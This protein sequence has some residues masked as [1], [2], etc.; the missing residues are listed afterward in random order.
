MK[1][2]AEDTPDKVAYNIM[3]EGATEWQS[4]TWSEYYQIC[5][6]SAKSLMALGLEAHEAIAVRG[7]NSPEWFA[8]DV[9]AIL[10][11]G[12]AAGIYTTNGPEASAYIVSHSGAKIV[13]VENARHLAIMLAARDQMP[14]VTTFVQWSGEVDASVE[15]LLSWEAFLAAGADVPDADLDARMEAT[16][17]GHCATLIYTSGTTGH[18][19]AVMV[20]H[21]N[22]TWNAKLTFS[23]ISKVD[24]EHLISFLPLSHVAGQMLDIIG[25]MITG[26]TIWFARPDALKGTLFDTVKAVRPTV[27]LAVPRVFEKLA[28]KLKMVMAA[29]AK[30]AAAAG[31]TPQPLPEGAVQA[32]LG[33]DRCHYVSTAAAPISLQILQFFKKIGIEIFSIYG[34]SENTGAS[35]VS[36]AGANKLGAVGKP[37][38]HTEIK[39]A[40]PDAEG[41]GEICKRGR[42]V[43][44]G[45]KDNEEAS[46]AAI[47]E[48]GFL[49]SGDLGRFD[50]DGFLHITGRI[51]ELLITAGGEN[52]GPVGIETYIKDHCPLLSNAIC[53]GDRRK[54]LSL[55]VAI[56]CEIDMTN[57]K[58][59]ETPTPDALA[60]LA[61]IGSTATTVSEAHACEKVKAYVQSTIDDYNENGSVSR[62]QL[63][64]KWEFL[65]EDV[66]I[67]NGCLTSTMKLK[68]RIVYKVFSDVIESMYVEA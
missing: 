37:M 20:T 6:Q 56:K 42:H 9:G 23:L 34:M 27:F 31:E 54:Y 61:K 24:E 15:G 46:A 13:F 68:R 50:E 14:N 39:L 59:T 67:G 25:P 38:P 57:G 3:P 8:A 60:V 47:D 32:M 18:P 63:I 12:V 36:L 51:K 64:R 19:K 52:V 41:N 35:S 21:D 4:T 10:A 5:R 26:G 33:L 17:P 43:F 11:G 44:A 2:R 40:D 29:K 45:Y 28:D 58:A 22:L 48:D 16:R 65:P 53:I 30:A 62:A 66:S 55:L 7:F 49:H 1:K